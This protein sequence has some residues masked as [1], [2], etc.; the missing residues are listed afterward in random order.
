MAIEP[1]ILTLSSRGRAPG[2]RD[3]GIAAFRG[4]LA[5]LVPSVELGKPVGHP[6][7]I[8]RAMAVPGDPS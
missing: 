3:G 2:E 4:M 6:E 1:M 7:R 5:G 8:A